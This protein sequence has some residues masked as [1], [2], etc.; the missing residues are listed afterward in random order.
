M[1][2]NELLT[3]RTYRWIRLSLKQNDCCGI[4]FKP[5]FSSYHIFQIL[6]YPFRCFQTASVDPSTGSAAKYHVSQCNFGFTSFSEI[7][8]RR[9][10]SLSIKTS[11][12]LPARLDADDARSGNPLKLKH[13]I[14]VCRYLGNAATVAFVHYMILRDYEHG[15]NR[16]M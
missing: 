1:S 12:H 5:T 10:V 4:S 16:Q 2:S 6:P 15:H 8:A 9:A 14:L 11:Q 13:F 3:L 7:Y